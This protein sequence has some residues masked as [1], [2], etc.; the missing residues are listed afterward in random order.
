MKARPKERDE[1]LRE[2]ACELWMKVEEVEVGGEGYRVVEKEDG[3]WAMGGD[4]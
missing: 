4:V 3:V 2:R 1:I